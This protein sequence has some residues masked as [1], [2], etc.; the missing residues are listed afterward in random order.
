MKENTVHIEFSLL[1]VVCILLT[2]TY[3]LHITLMY[4]VQFEIDYVRD[5]PLIKK[6]YNHV[7]CG[8]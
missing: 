6:C 8:K 5:L 2:Y 1:T 4:I 7:L 3:V